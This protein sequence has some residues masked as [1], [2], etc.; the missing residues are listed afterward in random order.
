MNTRA[1]R[2][3]LVLILVVTMITGISYGQGTDMPNYK[4]VKV[5][6]IIINRID[7]KDLETMPYTRQ[8]MDKSSIA[9][10]NTKGSGANNEFKSYA[11]LGW[12]VRSE[13]S[14]TTSLFYDTND[15][16]KSIY[17]RRTGNKL[18]ENGIVN[19][20]I[21]RLI[22]Q[23]QNGE[24]GALPGA[25]GQVLRENGYK[26]AVLGNGDTD[27]MEL[28]PAGLIV[29]DS[30]GYIDYGNIRNNLTEEDVTKPFGIKT[31]YDLLLEEFEGVY[32]DSNL[33]VIETGDTMRLE[34][35]KENLYPEA[36]EKQKSN[37]LNEIDNFI[38]DIVQNSD[39]DN[40]KLI[41]ATPYPSNEAASK[42]ERLT[43]LVIY[44]GENSGQVLYSGTTR[45][46]GIVGNVDIGP[47]ILSYFNLTSDKMTGRVLTSMVQE[48]NLSY[49]HNLNERVVNTSTQRVR[50]LY[51]F[52]V[53]EIITSIL[54]LILIVLR[55]RI[56]IKWHKYILLALIGNIVAPFTLLL[57]PL[58]GGT[59]IVVTYLLL[60]GLSI[61]IVIVLRLLSKGDPLSTILYAM[62]LLVFGLLIDTIT[63]Q[64]LIKNSLLGYDPIIGAR[65]YGIG[66][67]YMG[68]LIGAVL[69]FT[70]VFVEKYSINKYIPIIF[71]GLVTVIIGFPKLGANV[72]GTITAV[73]A[74]IFVSIR[75]LGK[76]INFK[77]LIYIGLSVIGVVGIMAIIDLF[78]IESQSHLAG[79]IRQIVTG[80][81]VVIYQIII[82]KISMNLRL[83]GVTIWSKVLLSAIVVLGILFYKPIGFIKKV[84][85]KYSKIAIGWSGIIVACIIG[86]AVNDSGI[87][88]AATSV[89]FL[90]STILYLIVDDLSHE[91]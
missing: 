74:F 30:N 45:R 50:V 19:L 71:Y 12:G 58:F 90:T 68:I 86:F 31:N 5:V 91:G 1:I 29:M 81:P 38:S 63:G 66:N 6:M 18:P 47:T 72:G 87:V 61:L 7:F 4:D 56:R 15:E 8:I 2:F 84:S 80:G 39:E 64:N 77:K 3:V 82:R 10:M 83:M 11:T 17:E 23:N 75:L 13:A 59:N 41:I 27:D 70:T 21:N 48:D 76:K 57:M 32:S 25:L 26:T 40:M 43:P 36:Y 9:L 14:H 24:Y 44:E 28:T 88:A 51:S 46:D 16:T 53:Y 62:T 73:F 79:A 33:I 89:V 69:V 22:T 49:I 42:G 37:I 35:Y 34:R 52:A 85:L 60:L 65:Y 54:A 67:E 78:I 55:K 20:D